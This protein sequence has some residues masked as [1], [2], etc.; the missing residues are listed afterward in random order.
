MVGEKGVIPRTLMTLGLS[1]L[2][3]PDANAEK[4]F[5]WLV[6]SRIRSFGIQE[7]NARSDA[8]AITS[9]LQA[10]FQWTVSDHWALLVDGEAIENFGGSFD[11]TVTG[12]S[13]YSLEP[14]PEGGELNRAQLTYT[15]IRNSTVTLGRQ[16]L[17]Y[18]QGRYFD[19]AGWRQNEQTYDAIAVNVKGEDRWSIDAGYIDK[20]H[21]FLGDDWA[22]TA[23][24][25]SVGFSELVPGELTLYTH[26]FGFDDTPA[27]SHRNLGVRYQRA[28]KLRGL[29]WSVHLELARQGSWRDGTNV[30]SVDYIRTEA[31]ATLRGID[32][33]VGRELLGGSGSYGFQAPFGAA[34]AY[35]GWTD[36][37][38]ITPDAGLDDR[39]IGLS[40]ALFGANATL[41]YHRFHADAGGASYGSEIEAELT[42]E[43]GAN[44]NLGAK[45][46]RYSADSFSVDTDKFWAFV[47]YSL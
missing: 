46:A 12:D 43:L 31:V 29:A 11:D 26:F 38:L 23:P 18:G 7:D 28:G 34:H 22:M 17:F 30:E 32:V 27:I 35:N 4:D 5:E 33:T 1:L 19:Y 15:G 21:T 6:E 45:Y 36:Q 47:S 20:V 16:R 37:F 8:S 41:R 3:I 42:R 39:Y 13:R 25:M 9:R 44:W 14:D 24:Y 40:G 2:L 10:G